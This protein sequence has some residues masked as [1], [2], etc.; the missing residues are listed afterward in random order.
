M[1]EL[2]GRSHRSFSVTELV[3][4]KLV[5]AATISPQCGEELP[6]NEADR[7]KSRVKKGRGIDSTC[8]HLRIFTQLYLKLN[9]PLDFFCL[10]FRLV[11][12]KF[13][14]AERVLVNM[15]EQ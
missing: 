4:Y 9:L 12:I 2:E 3:V 15:G 13:L 7:K 8:Y 10:W 5:A 11:W 1:L 14:P 6:E